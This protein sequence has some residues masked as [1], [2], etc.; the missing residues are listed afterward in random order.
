MKKRLEK[1]MK[2]CLI[3][4][5]LVAAAFCSIGSN[6]ARAWAATDPGA[7]SAGG[8]VVTRYVVEGNKTI[9]K[10]SE[11]TINLNIKHTTAT[12][13]KDEIDVSRLVDSFSGS[14]SIT[15]DIVSTSPVELNLSIS[16]LKYSGSG[17]SLRFMV[18]AGSTYEQLSLIHI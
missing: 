16:G 15:T 6:S 10:G 1:W 9:T 17:K 3:T 11:T 13:A 14:G 7:G 18:K 12:A 2:L 4:T 8:F 5:L